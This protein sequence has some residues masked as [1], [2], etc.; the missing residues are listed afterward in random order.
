MLKQEYPPTKVQPQP[1]ATRD[2]GATRHN[3]PLDYDKIDAE[4]GSILIA[5]A[6]QEPQRLKGEDAKVCILC[7]EHT[8]IPVA[9]LPAV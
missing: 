7:P 6:N 1:S 4:A 3:R 5:L 8:Q 2:D 9:P